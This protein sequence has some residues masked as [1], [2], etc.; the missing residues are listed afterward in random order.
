MDDRPTAPEAR[1]RGAYR[2]AMTDDGTRGR[3]P[4]RDAARA[5]ARVGRGRARRRSAGG[6]FRPRTGP[7]PRARRGGVR[8]R[9]AAAGRRRSGG[10]VRAAVR[11]LPARRTA[12]TA[13]YP[14]HRARLLA[15]LD[16]PAT[17]AD[18]PSR[19]DVQ[20]LAARSAQEVEDLA[21][22]VGAVA[23]RVRSADEWRASVPGPGRGVGPSRADRGARRRRSPA[24]ARPRPPAARRPPG[25]GS[26]PRHRRARRDPDARA[27]RRGRPARRPA[28]A[29][30]RS[31]SS[32][33]TRGRASGPRCSTSRP[34]TAGPGPRSC[35]TPPTCS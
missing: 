19:D 20:T 31:R 25:P 10:R 18:H 23:V 32:T 15:L 30:P 27:A 33:S 35:S 34:P 1:R 8:E 24:P 5:R 9:P 17:V 16:L 7:G 13:N 6:W 2:R 26:H 28:R 14:H 11:L 29:C 22:S 12:R 4:R 21:A 3:P